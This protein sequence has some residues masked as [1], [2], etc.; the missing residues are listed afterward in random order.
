MVVYL[1]SITGIDS[2]LYEAATLDGATKWQQTKYIT[3]PALKPI[4]VMMFILNVFKIT[5]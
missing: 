3:L 5:K 4:I 1:A 2:T